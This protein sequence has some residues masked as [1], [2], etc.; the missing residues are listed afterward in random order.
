MGN[1]VVYSDRVTVHSPSHADAGVQ[2]VQLGGAQCDL[3]VFLFVSRLQLH[4][5]QH[6][7]TALHRRHLLLHQPDR[8]QKEGA[9]QS[10]PSG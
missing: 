10:D 1:P 7:L 4:L 6:L 8:K 3:L 9:T 5:Q 2:V